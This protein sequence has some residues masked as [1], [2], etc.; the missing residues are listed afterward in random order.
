MN[1]DS[2]ITPKESG[3]GGKDGGIN[4]GNGFNRQHSDIPHII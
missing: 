1:C 3:Y 4:G 2:Q